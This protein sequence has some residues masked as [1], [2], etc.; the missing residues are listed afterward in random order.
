MGTTSDPER[1]VRPRLTLAD[2]DLLMSGLEREGI[3]TTTIDALE[4]VTE[5][6]ARLQR[7][8]WPLR[9]S[10]TI[11]EQSDAIVAEIERRAGEARPS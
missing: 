11:R 10:T 5:L 4:A 7:A 9:Q 6:S 8:S 1:T 3:A 2:I